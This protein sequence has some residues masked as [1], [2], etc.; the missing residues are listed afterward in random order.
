GGLQ[1]F[2]LVPLPSLSSQRNLRLSTTERPVLPGHSPVSLPSAQSLQACGDAC[3]ADWHEPPGAFPRQLRF[4]EE[5]DGS[6]AVGADLGDQCELTLRRDAEPP[7]DG[8]TDVSVVR[9]KARE[10]CTGECGFHGR[11]ARRDRKSTR[12]NSSHVS[13]SYAGFCFKKK[14]YINII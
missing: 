14:I 12:L 6:R 5:L 13:I 9:E 1:P 3:I 7:R 2:C 8:L 4:V 10:V 11:V